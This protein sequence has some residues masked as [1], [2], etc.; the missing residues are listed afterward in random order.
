MTLYIAQQCLFNH[1]LPHMPVGANPAASVQNLHNWFDALALGCVQSSS[2]NPLVTD[3]SGTRLP[4]LY[5]LMRQNEHSL[6]M[7]AISVQ[8]TWASQCTQNNLSAGSIVS[9]EPAGRGR[10]TLIPT[11]IG[12]FT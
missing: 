3:D 9:I 6:F 1:C 12:P 11:K 2:T 7:S 8:V 4:G 10:P 5:H